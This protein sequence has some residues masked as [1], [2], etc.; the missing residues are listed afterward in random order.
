ML[1]RLLAEWNDRPAG[2]LWLLPMWNPVLAAEQAGTLAAIAQGPFVVQCGVGAGD[3]QFRAMGASLRTRGRDLEQRL[4]V[5]TALLRG[6]AVDGVR[7]SPVPGA[8]GF[9]VW[10]GAVAPAAL[11]R[12]A[13]LGDA[14]YG[15]P[16][17]ED[18][19]AGALLA[20]FRAACDRHGRSPRASPLRRDVYVAGD[21]ND[22]ERVRS[23][24]AE[25]GHRGF[26]PGVVV[27]GTVPEVAERFRSLAALGF[28]EIVVRSLG[29]DQQAALASIDRL[30]DVRAAVSDL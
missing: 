5:M 4:G 19:R 22:A 13:R 26:R 25:Q 18:E 10:I 15:A 7:I 3:T 28:D 11:D 14:W 9:T 8:D 1:G 17:L 23:M 16:E 29:V 30:A 12:A 2:A 6:E 20:D 21:D 24:V 27:I